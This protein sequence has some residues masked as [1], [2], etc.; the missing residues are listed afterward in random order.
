ME[1]IRS[2]DFAGLLAALGRGNSQPPPPTV[3][4]STVAPA[5]PILNTTV[6][7]PNQIFWQPIPSG[8]FPNLYPQPQFSAVVPQPAQVTAV[9]KPKMNPWI[10]GGIVLA[11][12]VLGIIIWMR[13][14]TVQANDDG[15]NE[16]EEDTNEEFYSLAKKESREIPPPSVVEEIDQ[17]V[18][19]NVMNYVREFD[20]FDVSGQNLPLEFIETS[21][22]INLGPK[23]RLVADESQEVLDYAKRREA[24]FDK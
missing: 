19:D 5:L 2:D 23:K 6:P 14:M 17:H 1:T 18:A 9:V 8:S 4:P 3:L 22:K 13:S 20:S 11:V 21:D 7:A 15:D 16:E 10:I 12:I 24:L